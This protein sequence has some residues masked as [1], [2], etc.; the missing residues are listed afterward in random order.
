MCAYRDTTRFELVPAGASEAQ[1]ARI[2]ALYPRGRQ[3][4]GLENARLDS[5]VDIPTPEDT[6]VPAGGTVKLDLGVRAVCLRMVASH[7]RPGGG[8]HSIDPVGVPWAFFLLPRSSLAKTPLRLANSVGLIDLGYR[9]PLIACVANTG[10]A[11]Y[12]IRRGAALFQVAAADLAP[13]EYEVL[14]PPHPDLEK[15]F[16]RDSTLRGEKGFGS[17]GSSGSAGPGR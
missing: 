10:D 1:C 2:L 12:V 5:G 6:V 17:T 9:G 16:G 15:Y 7:H 8:V 4:L 14:R 11:D 3:R 13:A